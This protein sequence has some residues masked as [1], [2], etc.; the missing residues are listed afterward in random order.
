MASSDNNGALLILVLVG[1]YYLLNK[2]K[3]SPPSISYQP[4]PPTP[5]AI[6]PFTIP[7]VSIPPVTIPSPP[8][9]PPPLRSWWNSTE[10][11]SNKGS[12]KTNPWGSKFGRVDYYFPSGTEFLRTFAAEIR[13]GWTPKEAAKE[14]WQKGGSLSPS[15]IKT[16]FSE[17]VAHLKEDIESGH[18]S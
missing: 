15:T 1:A 10:W 3:T 18:W 5:P 9:K 2:N 12:I 17:S 6:P 13:S 11:M 8:Q 7:I 14:S 4:P 16:N